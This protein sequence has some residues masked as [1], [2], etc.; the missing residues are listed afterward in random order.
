MIYH[1]HAARPG[2]FFVGVM[3]WIDTG[4]WPAGG[5]RDPRAAAPGTVKQQHHLPTTQRTAASHGRRSVIYSPQ[6]YVW[7]CTLGSSGANTASEHTQI[8]ISDD[9]EQNSR[10]AVV[11][12]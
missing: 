9:R 11:R 2:A 12:G 1:T 8:I 5:S 6:T 10:L 4:L 7:M 3:G